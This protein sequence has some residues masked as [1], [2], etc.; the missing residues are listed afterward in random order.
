VRARSQPPPPGVSFIKAPP[1]C[2][3]HT[4]RPSRH[5]HLTNRCIITA[6]LTP[7]FPWRTREAS[8]AARPLYSACMCTLRCGLA[9]AVAPAPAAPAPPPPPA[10]GWGLPD[11]RARPDGA[12]LR[13]GRAAAGSRGSG[14]AGLAE[15]ADSSGVRECGGV[16]TGGAGSGGAA[17]TGS[18]GGWGGGGGSTGGAGAAGGGAGTGGGGTGGG[19]DDG[20]GTSGAL[21]A[22]IRMREPEPL[23]PAPAPS[24]VPCA[25]CLTSNEASTGIRRARGAPAHSPAK[26]AQ[27]VNCT[28][29]VSGAPATDCAPPCRTPNAPNNSSSISRSQAFHTA[30]STSLLNAIWNRRSSVMME[31]TCG[32][33]GLH[34]H[35]PG[36]NQP[37]LHCLGG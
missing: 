32:V 3:P 19:S 7:F 24:T 33:G 22:P 23:P 5:S 12:A 15:T 30:R 28:Q 35:H 37:T 6:A 9:A 31:S 16:A 1:M 36:A 4:K 8:L 26:V 10:A 14:D 20:S 18:W 29:H 17:G 25:E 11:A 34:A 27:P 2:T 13:G 21:A